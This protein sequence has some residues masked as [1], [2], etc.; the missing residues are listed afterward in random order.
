MILNTTF[1]ILG[2]TMKNGNRNLNISYLLCTY[3]SFLAHFHTNFLHALDPEG[4][5][6]AV[7][8][9]HCSRHFEVSGSGQ[10]GALRV[11]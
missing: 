5:L 10:C 3:G 2:Q 7:I 6:P 9:G 4:R 11:N 8:G 1:A